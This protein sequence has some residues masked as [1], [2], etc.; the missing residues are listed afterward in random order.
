MKVYHPLT[1]KQSV[2]KWGILIALILVCPIVYIGSAWIYTSIQLSI[3]RSKGVYPSAEYGMQSLL[4]ESYIGISR[5]DIRSAGP[6]SNDGSNPH[7]WYVIAEVRADSRADG[8]SLG[9][10]GCDAPGVFFLQT[11]AGWV[12]M[13]E[14]AFPGFI[15][16]WMKM[17]GMAGDGQPTPSRCCP[18][19][20]FCQW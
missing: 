13:P 5:I 1:I 17:F 11:K 15:G 4:E 20:H 19:E 16:T 10:N 9:R 14:G 2:I 3:A 6:N 8:S 12:W 7:V 18:P